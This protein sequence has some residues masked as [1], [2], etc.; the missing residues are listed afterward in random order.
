LT[1]ARLR[2]KC[3]YLIKKK[4]LSLKNRLFFKH[5]QIGV[6]F[7]TKFVRLHE[8]TKCRVF[9]VK[10]AQQ[11]EFQI[12]TSSKIW[13]KHVICLE[14]LNYASCFV[15]FVVSALSAY[16]QELCSPATTRKSLK[17]ASRPKLARPVHVSRQPLAAGHGSGFP[18]A[19]HHQPMRG[20]K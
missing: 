16:V 12:K 15:F 19:A 10:N 4:S 7:Q 17:S 3:A 2:R 1:I 8:K 5:D 6:L 9:C 13:K 20:L 14:K 11:M 18:G